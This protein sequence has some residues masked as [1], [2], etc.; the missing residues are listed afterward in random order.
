[1]EKYG[2]DPAHY[3]SWPGLSW[4]PLLKNMNIELELLKDLD[5]H[6]FI[7]RGMQGGISMSECYISTGHQYAG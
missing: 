2:P 4:D 5:I 3:L 1:M 7:E 6:L